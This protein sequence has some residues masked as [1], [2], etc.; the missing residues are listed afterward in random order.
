MGVRN[1][2]E[3]LWRVG[4]L[5]NKAVALLRHDEASGWIRT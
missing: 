2:Q 3:R 1:T 4:S 5:T